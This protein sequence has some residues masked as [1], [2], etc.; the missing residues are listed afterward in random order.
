MK[1]LFCSVVLAGA[2]GFMG[3]NSLVAG[4]YDIDVPHSSVDFQVK[5]MML[6]NV[7]GNFDKFSGVAEIDS[8]SKTLTKLEGT[9]EISSINTRNESRDKHM[10]SNEYFDAEKFPKGT[11]KMKKFSKE[12]NGIK[13]VA[14]LTLK[15]VTKEVVFTGELNGPGKN[16]MSKKE[17]FALNLNGKINRKNFNIGNDTSSA[18]MGEDVEIQIALELSAK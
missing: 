9:I 10:L 17:I 14:D 6:S 1:K 4:A 15:N 12:K 13:V 16:E 2:V 8:K 7:K 11:L 5:H 3:L 18:T